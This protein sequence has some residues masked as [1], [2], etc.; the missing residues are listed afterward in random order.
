MEALKAQAVAARTFAIKYT[1]NGSKSICT[2]EACQVFKNQRKGG[3]WERAVNDTRGWVLVDGGGNPV[4]T[5]YASTHGGYSNTS[6]WDTTD[7]S[8]DGAWSTRAWENKASSPWFYKAWYRNGYFASGDSCGRSHPWLSQ[9][10]FSDIINAWIVRNNPNG[11]DTSRIQPPTINQC[12]IGGGGNPYSMSELRDKANNSGGAVTNV[13][14]VS[15]SHSSS[16]QTT[17]VNV[18]TNRGNLSIPGSEFKSTFNLRAPGYLRIPQSSFGFFNIE[19]TGSDKS[20]PK[21][22]MGYAIVTI[23]MAVGAIATFFMGLNHNNRNY[24]IFFFVLSFILSSYVHV[25]LPLE[26]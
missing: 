1:D 17:A 7:K 10:E 6:G 26:C 19:D 14:S 21:G 25:L 4:S 5:Q 16:G 24:K 20:N 15:V 3:D 8:A 11:A 9:E 23:Y 2:T 12:Q 18:S 13:S 22:I